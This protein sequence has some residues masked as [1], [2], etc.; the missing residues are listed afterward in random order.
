MLTRETAETFARNWTQAWNDRDLDQIM[1]LYADGITFH[2]PRISQVLDAGM[3]SLTGKAALRDY[4]GVAL[5]S[6]PELYFEID[7][8]YLS[9]DAATLTYANHRGQQVAE[10]F[11][12]DDHG[13]VK[14]AIAA[15]G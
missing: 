12:F 7:A 1:A 3:M 11:V 9:S 6:A 13:R 8:I 4:W 15:Y 2:S 5:E 14:L 10:T